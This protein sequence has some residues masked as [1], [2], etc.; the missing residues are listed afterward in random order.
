MLVP[1][2]LLIKPTKNN[3]KTHKPQWHFFQFFPSL[4]FTQIYLS[5]TNREYYIP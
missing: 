2:N 5:S 3:N 1:D 4:T